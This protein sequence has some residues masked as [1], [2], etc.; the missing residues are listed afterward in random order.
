MDADKQ[1]GEPINDGEP[2]QEAK[3]LNR[4]KSARRLPRNLSHVECRKGLLGLG[5]NLATQALDISETGM[6]FVSKSQ[7]E[8]GAKVEALLYP[9]GAGRGI[10]VGAEVVRCEAMTGEGVMFEVAVTFERRLSYADYQQLT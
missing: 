8:Q 3:G 10:K 7:L 1:D 5:P 6:H 4:R 9:R 2:I